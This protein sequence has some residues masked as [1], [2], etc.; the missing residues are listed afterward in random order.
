[1]K[2]KYFL[3][4]DQGT[5]ST[6]AIIYSRTFNQ[7][8]KYEVKLKKYFP[9]NGWVEEDPNEIWESVK[10]SINKV[11]NKAKISSS[12][13]ISLAI[14]NQRETTVLWDKNTGKPIYNAIVWQDRR[15]SEYCNKI[16]TGKLNKS[17]QKITGLIIDPYFSATKVK[18][19]IDNIN[20]AKTLH[21]KKRLLFGTID[22]WIIWKLTNGQSHLTDITNASRTMLFDIN[23]NKWSEKLLKFFKIPKSI[24]P[25]V[26]EN[27]SNFGFTNIL[28]NK[29][30]IGGVAG[31]QQAA[32]IGQAC[33]DKG[34][35][36]STYGTGCF[37][38]MNIGKKQK[39]SKNKLLTTIAYKIHGQKN[40]CLEGSIFVAGSSIQ[41]LRD[42]LKIINSTSSSEKLYSKADKEQNVYL[43]PAFNG[44]GAPYWNS[45][46]R[47][48]IY[49]LTQNTGIAEI[50]KAAIQAVCYQT[51]DLVKSMEKDTG[52]KINEIRVDGGMVNNISFLKFLSD[53]LGIKIITSR[54]IESTAL[55]ATFLA[56]LHSGH[57][58]DVK[59]I[60]KIWKKN[61]TYKSNITTE[62]RK[63]LYIGWVNAIKKTIFLSD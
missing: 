19:I 18:W 30:S 63:K 24:L 39:L 43:V 36:K 58:K 13:I 61:K 48:A 4:I 40:Y 3:T 1:M 49:G 31:D 45:N 41:W 50:V 14:T 42:S 55:G 5:S 16:N 33:F 28:G 12:D 60:Q 15:T 9:H 57:I 38:L 11:I 21:K 35:C 59:Q 51:K 10:T 25:K 53:I 37:F 44:L 27:V 23:K 54:Y 34:M 22:T 2:K 62:D 29:I 52:Q 56:A 32:L 26:K 46:V 47:G 20:V 17:I 8:A 6:R 7:I